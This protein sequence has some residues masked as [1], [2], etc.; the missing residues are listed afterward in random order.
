M[1]KKYS[2]W[3]YDTKFRLEF[4]KWPYNLISSRVHFIEFEV[5]AILGSDINIDQ[6]RFNTLSNSI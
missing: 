5:Q 4:R 3:N 6:K 1:L 2:F